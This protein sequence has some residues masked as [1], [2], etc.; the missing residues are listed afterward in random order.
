MKAFDI[1]EYM[2]CGGTIKTTD[3]RE[4]AEIHNI[5]KENGFT[6]GFNPNSFSAVDYPYTYYD[7]GEAK[8]HGSVNGRDGSVLTYEELC[9]KMVCTEADVFQPASSESI[10]AMLY[11][12]ESV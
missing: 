11:G 3:T 12:E 8:I 7:T 4:R 10:M 5:L 2:L 6:I 1:R 9:S